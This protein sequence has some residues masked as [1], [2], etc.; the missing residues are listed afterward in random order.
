MA[1]VQY[2]K[3]FNESHFCELNQINEVEKPKKM[4]NTRAHWISTN[5]KSSYGKC[6][7]GLKYALVH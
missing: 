6:V 2:D 1:C 3:Y 7:F 4:K 5:I